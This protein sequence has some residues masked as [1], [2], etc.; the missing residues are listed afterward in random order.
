M[1]EFTY[2]IKSENGIHARPAGMLVKKAGE[3][4]CKITIIVGEKSADAKRLFSVMGLGAKKDDEIKVRIE[5]ND[6]ING[7]E[8]EN[9][10]SGGEIEEE[11]A[12]NELR[13]FIEQNF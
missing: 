3:L 1:R 4:N 6:N 10:V 13:S 12:E 7:S 2:K 5:Y 9:S 11:K 8:S